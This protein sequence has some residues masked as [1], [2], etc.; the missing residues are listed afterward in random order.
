MCVC[1][2]LQSTSALLVAVQNAGM[3]LSRLTRKHGI[4]LSVPSSHSVEDCSLAVGQAVS[5]SRVKSTAW[6]NGAVVI[7]LDSII[8]VNAVV[9]SGVTV[10]DMFVS[11]M[12]KVT[13]SNVSS[14]I[15]D[16]TLINQLAKHGK[17][18]SHQKSPVRLQVSSVATRSVSQKKRS[19]NP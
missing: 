10:N 8:K 4:K 15:K 13:I 14:F 1:A 18:V 17:T 3:D 5:H 16:E 6:M 7:F 9:E 12:R 19:D 2:F 11:V